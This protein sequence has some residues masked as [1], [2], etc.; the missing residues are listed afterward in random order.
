[1]PYLLLF[2]GNN[3]YAN[4]PECHVIFT[5]A[6]RK[7]SSHFEYFETQLLDLDVAWQPVRELTVLP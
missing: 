4:A 7:L 5:R 1:M 3:G 2:D 6:V